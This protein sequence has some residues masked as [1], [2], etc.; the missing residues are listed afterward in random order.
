MSRT[1]KTLNLRV[2]SN[3]RNVG[4]SDRQKVISP[5]RILKVE[6][7]EEL[8]LSVFFKTLKFLITASFGVRLTTGVLVEEEEEDGL[9]CST[10]KVG[11]MIRLVLGRS[12]TTSSCTTTM[13]LLGTYLLSSSSIFSLSL[14]N[15]SIS[16]SAS[17]LTH[18]PTSSSSCVTISSSTTCCSFSL[19]RLFMEGNL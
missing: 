4:T 15:A 2:S 8:P 5:S 9:F 18:S 14:R 17:V 11:F 19:R 12:S 10:L 3:L 7:V 16:M 13:L 6:F 1:L